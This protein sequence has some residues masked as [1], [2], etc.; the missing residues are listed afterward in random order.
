MVTTAD[1]LA[2]LLSPEGLALLSAH[3]PDEAAD[4]ASASELTF[5]LRKCDH[6]A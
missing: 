1:S 6:P 5:E 2:Q 3:C 4:D